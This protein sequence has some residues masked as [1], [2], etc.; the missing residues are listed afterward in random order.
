MAVILV[1]TSALFAEDTPAVSAQPVA[2]VQQADQTSCPM[3]K[4]KMKGCSD[5]ANIYE[6]KA[7]MFKSKAEKA[8]SKGDTKLADLYTKCST[9]AQN[10]SDQMKNLMKLKADCKANAQCSAM[11]KEKGC[12]AMTPKSCMKMAQKCERMAQKMSKNADTDTAKSVS[13]IQ[14]KMAE[15]Y[16]TLAAAEESFAQANKDLRDYK[17]SLKQS[18]KNSNNQEND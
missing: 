4:D 13:M 16:K 11:D 18:K 2:S 7:Q 8:S 9:A 6:N 3:M 10:V 15:H 17:K 12:G 5:A 14:S 1:G